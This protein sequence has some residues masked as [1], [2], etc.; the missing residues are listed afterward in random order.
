MVRGRYVILVSALSAAVGLIAAAAYE[1]REQTHRLAYAIYRWRDSL[2]DLFALAF[3]PAAPLPR[4]ETEVEAPAILGL[5][6]V[7]AFAKRLIERLTTGRPHAQ[8]T[9]MPQ[10]M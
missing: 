8:M 9:L 10:L 3:R 6:Q 2:A 1:A 4:I 5:S 7:R